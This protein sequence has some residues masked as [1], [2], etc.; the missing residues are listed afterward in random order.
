MDKINLAEEQERMWKKLSTP[1]KPPFFDDV[2]NY[3]AYGSYSEIIGYNTSSNG[4]S[5]IAIGSDND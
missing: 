5:N 1:Y 2:G 4:Q 3:G